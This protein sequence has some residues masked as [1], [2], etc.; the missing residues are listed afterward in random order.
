MALVY[1][2][3]FIYP[4]VYVLAVCA[5]AA[6]VLVP[7]HR[8]GDPGV[9]VHAHPGSPARP[10]DGRRRTRCAPR[11][12]PLGPLARRAAARPHVAAAS[13][14]PS[15]PRR[16]SSP[17]SSGRSAPRSATCLASLQLLPQQLVDDLRVGLALRLASSPGRRGSRARPPCRRGRSR[18]APG[19]R[20][21]RRRSTGASADS[22]PTRRLREVV[23]RR[24]SGPSAAAANASSSASRVTFASTICASA[25]AFSG[26][27]SP[28]FIATAAA[29]FQSTPSPRA[30]RPSTRC[31]S[32]TSSSAAAKPSSAVRRRMRS[33]GSS[34][35]LAAQPLDELRRRLDRHEVGLGE[36]AVVVGL[37]LRA[38]HREPV[39]VGV[40]VVRRLLE[41][42]PAPRAPRP[43]A[44]NAAS[45]AAAD[46]REASSCS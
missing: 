4:S 31:R 7:E 23:V 38:V 18:P 24:R 27:K 45:I 39:G 2:A 17:R 35:E 34:R 14:S 16:S 40:V 43:A 37:L 28:R 25:A 46:E 30:P 26:R 15:S 9:L 32:I 13:R 3:F 33:P 29:V 1:V 36:V 11:R 10:G 5:R 8:L 42:L 21:G 22:S 6:R 12:R 20:R 19:S 44:R 41:L